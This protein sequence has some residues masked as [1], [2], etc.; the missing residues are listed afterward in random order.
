MTMN[1]TAEASWIAETLTAA[2]RDDPPA[3]GGRRPQ[4]IRI[5]QDGLILELCDC[6][7]PDPVLVHGPGP[8]PRAGQARLHC[9]LRGDGLLAHAVLEVARPE[10]ARF[11]RELDELLKSG[12]GEASIAGGPAHPGALRIDADGDRVTLTLLAC[13]ASPPQV[14]VVIEELPLARNDL[15]S[16]H[17]WATDHR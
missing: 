10:I 2:C 3:P 9:R 16:I 11:V 8:R 6:V 5:E 1:Q 12:T 4:S 14:R 15:L 7:A 13:P 17:R